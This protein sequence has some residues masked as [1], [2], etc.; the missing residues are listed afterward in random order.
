MALSKLDSL[1]GTISKDSEGGYY[2]MDWVCL[3]YMCVCM[4]G[5]TVKTNKYSRKYFFFN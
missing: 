1:N 4:P 3:I 5:L 2:L